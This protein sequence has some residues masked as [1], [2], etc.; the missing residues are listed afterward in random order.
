MVQ[1]FYP[2]KSMYKMTTKNKNKYI[3]NES[4]S[5]GSE[6]KKITKMNNIKKIEHTFF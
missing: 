1:W 6:S 3:F 2:K 5:I 4:L